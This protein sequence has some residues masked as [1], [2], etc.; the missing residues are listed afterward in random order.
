MA[1]KTELDRLRAE[2]T[3]LDEEISRADG[4]EIAISE[5]R[6][7]GKK[8]RRYHVKAMIARLEEQQVC[9]T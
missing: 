4:R 5:E 6:L 3:S 9:T 2:H 8:R 7:K 1:S